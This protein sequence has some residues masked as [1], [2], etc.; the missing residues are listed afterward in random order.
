MRKMLTE[1]V[2]ILNLVFPLGAS[3][4]VAFMQNFSTTMSVL[5]IMLKD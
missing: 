1:A 4:P 3:V 5:F 2:S